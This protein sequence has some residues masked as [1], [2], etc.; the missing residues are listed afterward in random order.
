MK[1]QITL[2]ALMYA[3]IAILFLAALMPLLNQGISDLIN[4]IG[5][6]A[7]ALGFTM[8]IIPMLIY[9]II[10]SVHEYSRFER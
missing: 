5:D 2:S 10:R 4:N 9:A 6:N 7:I 8:L 3:T 1:G